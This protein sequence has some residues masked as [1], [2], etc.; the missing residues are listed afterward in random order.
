MNRAAIYIGHDECSGLFVQSHVIFPSVKKLFAW[1]VR[2]VKFVML[3]I[4]F[5]K[6]IH[7]SHSGRLYACLHKT[8]DL[9]K[10]CE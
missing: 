1:F 8:W 2:S 7:E 4:E 10:F 9:R 3:F 5:L 6:L